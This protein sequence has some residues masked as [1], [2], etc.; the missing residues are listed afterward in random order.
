MDEY[1]IIIIAFSIILF[2]V[3]IYLFRRSLGAVEDFLNLQTNI[4]IIATND[5]T[6]FINRSGLKFFGFDTIKDF[7]K[8]VKSI[9]RLF[10]EED[11]CVSRYSH[12]KSW[13][14][15]IYNSKQSM[16]KIKIK[17]PADRRM[18]YFF[19]IQVSRLKGDRYLLIFTILQAGE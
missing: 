17:T 13:L 3:S 10:L 9:N 15:K 6:I 18:D 12:G 16:A 8:E 5:S 14:E 1:N 4:S 11:S 2:L 7:Q 19:Y